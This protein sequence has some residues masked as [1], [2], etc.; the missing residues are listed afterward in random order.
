MGETPPVSSSRMPE[1][2]ALDWTV[3]FQQV[4]YG[5]VNGVGIAL[6]ATGFSVGLSVVGIINM[7]H[8]ELCMLGAIFSYT[9]MTFLGINYFVAGV[10]AILAI[11]AFGY[12]ISRIAVQPLLS[13]DRLGVVMSTI[14]LG[15]IILNATIYIF[16]SSPKQ[17]VTP[18]NAVRDIGGVAISD[19]TVLLLVVGIAI[20][21][22]LHVWLSRSNLGR[23]MR[24]TAGNELGA[25]LTGINIHAIYHSAIVISAGL[26]A[27]AGVLLA[28]MVTASPTLGQPMLLT[29]FAILVIAG[30]NSLPAIIWVGLAV[31][32]AQA[33][34]GQY[35]STY[36]SEVFVYAIMVLVLLVKPEGIGARR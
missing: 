2:R 4:W 15:Y 34:F 27:V 25:Q 9:F 7:A 21:V 16:G 10:I 33:L 23:S 17:V 20:I 26:A 11:A 36:Y 3:F 35:V 24:A 5:L 19:Q 6:F 32:V 30:V 1:V 18:L 28:P 8:G 22:F 31:S 29:A 14:A 12:V 13:G